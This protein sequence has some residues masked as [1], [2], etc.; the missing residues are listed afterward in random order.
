MYQN[1]AEDNAFFRWFE[2][3]KW[4]LSGGIKI[5]KCRCNGAILELL[6]G[7]KI[8]VLW[9]R[10]ARIKA[11]EPNADKLVCFDMQMVPLVLTSITTHSYHEMLTWDLLY[12]CA[13]EEL[14][15][16]K[17]TVSACPNV[18]LMIPAYICVCNLIKEV[19]GLSHK[20]MHSPLLCSMSV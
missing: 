10:A 2:R 1:N 9:C 19:N 16:K 17:S 8:H 4:K 20:T 6:A 12:H 15:I 11:L 7:T 5:L 3:S 13:I 14:P 18:L